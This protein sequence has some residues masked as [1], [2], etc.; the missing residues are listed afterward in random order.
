MDRQSAIE[1]MQALQKMPCMLA[2]FWRRH[3][4]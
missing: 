2:T 1:S 4:W 3:V